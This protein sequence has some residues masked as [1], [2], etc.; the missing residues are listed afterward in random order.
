[1]YF[2]ARLFFKAEYL[3]LFGSP[4]RFRRWA[5]VLFFTALFAVMWMAVTIGRM[6]DFVFFPRFCRQSVRQPVF[7][8]APPRSG[9]TLL[10]KLMSLDE[11]RF[12]Y[13]KMYQ[14]IFPSI[15]YQRIFDAIGWL[16]RRIGSPLAR[17]VDWLGG[18]FFGGWDDMH[19]MRF[20]Q[21]EEDDGFF[22]YTFV[23]EAIFLLF[24]FIDELWEAGFADALPD[25][26]RQKLMAY[27]R[28]CL[29]RQLYAN[30]RNKV[31][32]SKA[33][34]ACGSIRSLLEAF[35]DARFITIIRHPYQSVASHVSVFYPVWKA[36]SP[37]IARD[38]AVSKSYARLAVE[39]YRHVHEMSRKIDPKQYYCVD[40]RELVSDPRK[41]IEKIYE[42]FLMPVSPEFSE[43]LTEAG[44][45]ERKF[46]S[47]HQYTLEE[48]GLSREWIGRELGHLMDAYSLER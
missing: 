45:R 9:T 21:P 23:T 6:L 25:R 11:E 34:Q 10:Q 14:L 5:Y 30:G 22:V 2:N 20:N 41:T 29:Q 7:I 15:C 28:G 17:V 32:L 26:E 39:W 4:F 44:R 3:A 37:E 27:Y 12:V 36:H 1:M 19:P 24:P 40:Y 38:S 16:D 31:I 13:S 43:R 42:H 47:A 8:I 48:F 46:K 35:P 18:K 33:T